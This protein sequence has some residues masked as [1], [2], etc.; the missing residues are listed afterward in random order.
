M[1][2]TGD[3]LHTVGKLTYINV[4]FWLIYHTVMITVELM[5]IMKYVEIEIW[6]MSNDIQISLLSSTHR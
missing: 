4:H 1:R 5:D 3:K 6:N 2:E